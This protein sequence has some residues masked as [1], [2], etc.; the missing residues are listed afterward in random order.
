LE[1]SDSI[2]D[3]KFITHHTRESRT[4][5]GGAFFA[6][7]ARRENNSIVGACSNSSAQ[8]YCSSSAANNA[9]RTTLFSVDI[10]SALFN[11]ND[12]IDHTLFSEQYCTNLINF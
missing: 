10:S 12:N 2:P 8:Q 4:Q 3:S 1:S 5:K 6:L 11:H 7:Y 9:D